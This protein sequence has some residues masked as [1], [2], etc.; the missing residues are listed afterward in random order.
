MSNNTNTNTTA[1]IN[2]LNSALDAAAAAAA[3]EKAVAAASRAV[4]EG[5][6]ERAEA[7][8]ARWFSRPVEGAPSTQK[9]VALGRERALAAYTK[10]HTSAPTAA[11]EAREDLA[12]LRRAALAKAGVASRWRAVASAKLE[13][14]S[15][16][17]RDAAITAA[18]RGRR[19]GESP[20]RDALGAE[21]AEVV[22]A[23]R[24]LSALN[25]ARVQ[26]A[27]EGRGEMWATGSSRPT[28]I[29]RLG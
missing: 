18:L 10:A 21:S 3:A 29:R 2:L 9:Q 8:I 14:L 24:A 28:V 11:D 26:R 5:A 15:P 12:R 17:G 4:G 23:A 13:A 7:S 27:M 20:W 1:I 19:V 25:A 22:V 6:K 16:Q